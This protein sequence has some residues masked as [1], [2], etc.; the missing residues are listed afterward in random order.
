MTEQDLE[1]MWQAATSENNRVKTLLRTG[2]R[3][4]AENAHI[5][6]AL[7]EEMENDGLQYLSV[8]SATN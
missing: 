1:T 7:K 6:D 5:A 4:L 3:K 2:G 8:N